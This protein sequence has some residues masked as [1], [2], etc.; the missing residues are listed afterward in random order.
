MRDIDDGRGVG[1]DDENNGKG[2]YNEITHNY[3]K[4]M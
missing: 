1:E 2:S 3:S 4:M